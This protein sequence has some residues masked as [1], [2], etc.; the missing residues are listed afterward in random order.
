MLGSNPEN[1]KR[2]RDADRIEK[3]GQGERS[4]GDQQYGRPVQQCKIYRARHHADTQEQG[5]IAK[6]DP[7]HSSFT[8]RQAR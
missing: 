2:N 8:L 7:A 5:H 1:E 4:P 6:T 3:Y